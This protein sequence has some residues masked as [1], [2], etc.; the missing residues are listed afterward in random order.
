VD[1]EDWRL[2]IDRIDAELVQL[3]NRRSHCAIEIGRI[4]RALDMPIYSPEREKQV[5]EH[6]KSLNPGPLGN[7]AI[8]RLFERI[9]DESRR[10]ERLTIGAYDAD[11]PKELPVEAE[12]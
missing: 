11:N 10:L 8:Q 3:L 4:K 1:I 6:V 9:I 5:I 7:D 12:E 2:E